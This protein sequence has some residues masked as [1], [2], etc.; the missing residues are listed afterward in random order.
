[1]LQAAA[2]SRT[3]KAR[4][5]R[6]LAKVNGVRPF[7]PSGEGGAGRARRR[8]TASQTTAQKGKNMVAGETRSG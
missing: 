5:I 2:I 6:S 3:G 4:N 1:V 8:G 7:L